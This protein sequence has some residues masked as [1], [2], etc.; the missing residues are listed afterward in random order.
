MAALLVVDDD[1]GTLVW[2]AAALAGAGHVVRTAG[3]GRAALE[4]VEAGKPDLILADIMMPEMDGFAFSR[5]VQAH[6]VPVMLV[7]ALQ[8]EAEAVLRGVAGYVRKPVT[9]AELRA[10]VDRVLGASA[11]GAVLLVDDDP[12]IRECMRLILAPRFS[13]LEAGDGREALAVLAAHEV[14]LLIVDVHMPVMNGV[15]LV[16]TIRDDPALRALPVIVQTGDRAATRAPIWTDLHVEQ[17]VLKSDFIAW[18][19]AHIEDHLAAARP[20]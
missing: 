2:M 16:R 13:V 17:T 4:A 10:A 18:L 7:S 19:L 8:K 14:A 6:R 9:A 11:A 15:E 12:D 20:G 1:E 5:L 3:S